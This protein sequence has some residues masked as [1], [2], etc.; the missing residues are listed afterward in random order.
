MEVRWFGLPGHR[1]VVMVGLHKVYIDVRYTENTHTW[2]FTQ[3]NTSLL[4]D[5][6]FHGGRAMIHR[7]V[8]HTSRKYHIRHE[9]V[10]WIRSRQLQVVV[11]ERSTYQA[12]SHGPSVHSRLLH[13][14][15]IYCAHALLARYRAETD[16]ILAPQVTTLHGG[17]SLWSDWNFFVRSTCIYVDMSIVCMCQFSLWNICHGHI[18]KIKQVW[19][20]EMHQIDST[21]EINFNN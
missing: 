3:P 13:F 6:Y 15:S 10:Q 20:K 14:T 21:S 9:R 1:P 16:S 8:L 7:N 12:I 17:W 19:K 18:I 4:Y 2:R 11:A 5:H